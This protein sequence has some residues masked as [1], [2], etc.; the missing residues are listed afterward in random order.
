MPGRWTPS[1]AVGSHGLPLIGSGDWNDGMN[2]VGE[3]GRGES[4]W[5][6]WLLHAALDAFA[7]IADARG[8][9]TRAANWR[10]HMRA[11]TTALESEAWDGDWYR[12]AWFDDGTPLGS[13]TNEECRI[14]FYFPILGS[15]LR[16]GAARPRGP[17]LWRP[18]TAS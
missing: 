10:E 16:R 8:D 4:V 17:R 18:S 7:T 12:R 3:G 2:R 9:A 11:L 5:L 13:A 1:L 6:G 15:D 14:E